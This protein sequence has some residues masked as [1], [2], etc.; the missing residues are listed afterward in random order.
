MHGKVRGKALP[1]DDPQLEAPQGG[2]LGQGLV[3]LGGRQLGRVAGKGEQSTWFKHGS[4]SSG[5]LS[6]V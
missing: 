2:A 6:Q 1:L 5:Q 4:C 3:H